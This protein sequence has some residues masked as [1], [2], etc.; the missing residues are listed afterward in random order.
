MNE[1]PSHMVLFHHAGGNASSMQAIAQR[2]SSAFSTM[3]MEMPGRGRRR[4]EALMHDVSAIVDD[5]AARIPEQGRLI[6][7]G[8]SLGAYMAY[9]LAGHC[10]RM[11]PG[12]DIVL[13]VMSNDPIHCRR[14]FPWQEL[15]PES[16][17]AIWHFATRLG[18][19]PDWLT[20]DD[21]LRQ[22]FI[23]VLAADLAVANSIRA[24]D[25]EPLNGVPVLLIYGEGDPY[26]SDAPARWCECTSGIYRMES[27]PGG[28]FIQSGSDTSDIISRFIS[29][30]DMEK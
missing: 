15:N 19:L 12:R 3:L 7:V 29:D 16:Q 5:F 10:Q 25:T 23:Q 30:V 13:V 4:Q 26:L 20:Q 28:H 6:L 24:E 22:Q 9:L 21:V 27:V 11:T 18:E 8:H 17:Q 1:T 14:R 2:F